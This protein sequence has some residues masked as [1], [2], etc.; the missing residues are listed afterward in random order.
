MK[1][2]ILKS[3]LEENVKMRKITIV[4]LLGFCL[5]N[6]LIYSESISNSELASKIVD[7][8]QRIL[9]LEKIVFEGN[10]KVKEVPAIKA[11]WRKLE[12]NMNADE[13][14]KLLGEPDEISAMNRL[15]V[16]I[17]PNDGYVRFDNSGVYSWDWPVNW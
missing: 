13:V 17:Y 15:I 10:L 9:Q 4:L 8:E 16:W 12:L 1:G 7:L 11:I 5:S 6:I 3:D 14:R 2:I